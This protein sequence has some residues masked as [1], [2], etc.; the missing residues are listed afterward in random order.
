LTKRSV[1]STKYNFAT[2]RKLAPQKNK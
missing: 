2:V 1:T